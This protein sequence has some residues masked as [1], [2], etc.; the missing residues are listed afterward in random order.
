[1]PPACVLAAETAETYANSFRAPL[2][3]GH[4][5]WEVEIATPEVSSREAKSGIIPLPALKQVVAKYPKALAFVRFAGVP[6]GVETLFPA[7][8]A[9]APPL[10]V[11]DSGG[12]TNWVP[13]LVQRRIRAVIVPRP[14]VDVAAASGLAG[15]PGEIFGKLYYLATPETAAQIA[16][17][18]AEPSP[19]PARR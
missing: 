14:D 12:T 19:S 7:E 18:L 5:E 2:L 11:Y 10:F 15:M 17:K 1:M 6:T 16:A 8:P 9:A 3:R 4:P 13:A